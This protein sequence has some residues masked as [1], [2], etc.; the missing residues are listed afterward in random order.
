VIIIYLLFDT[1]KP[2]LRDNSNGRGSV[3]NA[4]VKPLGGLTL[5]LE[6]FVFFERIVKSR[7]KDVSLG[8]IF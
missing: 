3:E 5:S 4:H 8:E 6:A 7:Y 2:L 1:Y